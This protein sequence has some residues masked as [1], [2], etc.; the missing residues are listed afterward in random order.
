MNWNL[1]VK[2]GW[3]Q[4]SHRRWFRRNGLGWGISQVSISAPPPAVGLI[5]L[6]ELACSRLKHPWSSTHVVIIPRL[7]YQEEWRG[8]FEKEVDL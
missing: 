4:T 8:W 5:V 3:N 6:K 2:V 7:L 1:G